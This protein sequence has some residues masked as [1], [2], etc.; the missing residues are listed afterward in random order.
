YLSWTRRWRRPDSWRLIIN[1]YKQGADLLTPGRFIAVERGGVLRAGRIEYEELGLTEEG[2]IS[3]SWEKRGHGF[4]GILS[5]RL[6]LHG[7]A[8]GSGYDVQSGTAEA[9]MR[10]YVNG[11]VINPTDPARAV[12]LLALE[13]DQERGGTVSYQARFQTVAEVL[14]DL[15]LASGLGWDTPMATA[16]DGFLFR[17]LAGRDLTPGNGVYPPVIFSPEFGNVRMLQY[18]HSRM[19]SRNVLYVAGQG[20]AAARVV[21]TVAI[22]SP[23][24]LARREL[25]VDARDLELAAQLDQRGAE[26]LAELGEETVLEVEHLPGGPFEYLGDFDLGDIVHVRYPDV[27]S[28]EARIIEVVE[29]VTP[30]QGDSYRLVVGREWPDLLGV[31]RMA[32]K[33][34]YGEVR[35]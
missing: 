28:M 3:E 29:D 15:S 19:D 21:R 24:G 34:I 17:V 2:K 33:Q 18:R 30:E 7:T 13:A 6:A 26:R 9:A 8:A 12:S 22:G 5:H 10:H 31:W 16:M 32:Q 11:N 35:R 20:E 4:G 23:A 25:F 27:A 1:R 14:E